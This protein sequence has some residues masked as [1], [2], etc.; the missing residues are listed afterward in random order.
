MKISN[1]SVIIIFWS[2]LLFVMCSCSGSKNLPNIILVSID[3][4]RADRV[5]AYGAIY[6]VTPMLD[7]LAAKGVIFKNT[8]SPAPW[9]LPAHASLFTG[10]YPTT[11]KAIDD[12]VYIDPKI[13]MLAEKLREAGYNTAAFVSHYY[14]SKDYGF[15]RGFKKFV[16]NIDAPAETMTDLAINW[17]KKNRKSSFFLFLHYFDPHTPY[18]PPLN[19]ARKHYPAGVR[20][21]QGTTKDVISVIQKWPS[22]EAKETL[23][24]LE[25]LY[26][27]EI[28]FVDS[29][30][31]ELY[32]YLQNWNLDTDTILI[33]VSDHGEEFMDHGLMEHGFTLHEEQLRVPFIIHCPKRFPSH[34][35]IDP[36]VSLI[37]VMPTLLDM[38]HI[39]IPKSVQG[40]SLL[41]LI[42]GSE[43]QSELQNRSLYGETTRQGP[44]RMCIISNSYKYFYSPFFSLN[45]VH[46]MPAL[47]DLEKDSG[48]HKNLIDDE[49][50]LTADLRK[51]LLIE[52]GYYA[53][54]KAW[55]IKFSG[56]KKGNDVY[57]GKISTT[58]KFIY[59][60]KHDCLYDVDIK[61]ILISNEFPLKKEDKKLE[62][63]AFA[64]DGDNG[65]TFSVEP[66][67]ASVTF[68]L[69]INTKSL[70]QDVLIGSGDKHPD[71]I[72]FSLS[73]NIP[74][75]EGTENKKPGYLICTET[76]STF[77]DLLLKAE[78]G[79]QIMISDEM[80]QKLRSLGYIQGD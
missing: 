4:L 43:A 24:G 27:G 80:K 76:I 59:V 23:R 19:Y 46:F 45:H 3:T 57:K 16:M 40:R 51:K 28:D 37:D 21:V 61:G 34:Q 33:V 69:Q 8:Y 29:S 7:H 53:S 5:G 77:K 41:P 11:H 52:S 26:L 62:F 72:P 64:K 2:F 17:L 13:P 44:D 56:F 79:D 63:I 15:D 14:L 78:I 12:K 70:P 9:T 54:R 75:V 47:F 22:D 18:N 6:N 1:K 55:T 60:F 39:P 36:K 31:S 68:N 74:L 66:E 73:G 50:Q 67:D 42:N 65:I 10:V 30:F 20:V 58:G 71:L 48:E 25:A 49:P 38:L 32:K 35:T